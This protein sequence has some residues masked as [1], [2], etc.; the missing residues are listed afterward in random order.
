MVS[1]SKGASDSLLSTFKGNVLDASGG[2]QTHLRDESSVAMDET[3]STSEQPSKQTEGGDENMTDVSG[4]LNLQLLN[5]AGCTNLDASMAE[6]S[7]DN[8]LKTVNIDKEGQILT[9]PTTADISSVAA[10]DSLRILNS[11]ANEHHTL[12]LRNNELLVLELQN[13]IDKKSKQLDEAEDKLSSV[14]GEVNS[15]K[16]E[17]ENTRGLLDESQVKSA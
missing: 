15:L 10:E 6:F 12:E 3:S 16:T 5:S 17:L 13:T 1:G 7:R 11:R 4:A 2:R 8:E 9:Q 14:M